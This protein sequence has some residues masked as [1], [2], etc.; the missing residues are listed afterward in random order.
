MGRKYLE[1]S[2]VKNGVIRKMQMQQISEGKEKSNF[3]A[4]Y[5][6]VSLSCNGKVIQ[7]V[8]GFD[9]HNAK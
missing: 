7:T 9:Y 3:G 5:A 2:T 4:I 1:N 6:E 8:L